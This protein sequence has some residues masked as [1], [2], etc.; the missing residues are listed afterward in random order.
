MGL[1][2]GTA[3]AVPSHLFSVAA[4]LRKAKVGRDRA[5]PS[6]DKMTRMNRAKDDG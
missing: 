1:Q 4:A 3:S 6:L 2:G 5:R